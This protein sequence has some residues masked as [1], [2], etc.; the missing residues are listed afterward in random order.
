MGLFLP[1]GLFSYCIT[2]PDA[3]ILSYN[4]SSWLDCA[5]V[6]S[7]RLLQD[8]GR[9]KGARQGWQ[10]TLEKTHARKAGTLHGVVPVLFVNHRLQRDNNS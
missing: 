5:A 10:V 8:K 9:N 1:L 7:R 6:C 2:V 3:L 4:D